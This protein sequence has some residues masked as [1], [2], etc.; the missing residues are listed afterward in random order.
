MT[1]AANNLELAKS[2]YLAFY[3]PATC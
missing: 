3:A 1:F 2:F